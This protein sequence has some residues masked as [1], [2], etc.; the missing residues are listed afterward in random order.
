MVEEWY[1]IFINMEEKIGFKTEML[2]YPATGVHN[3]KISED[4]IERIRK[5]NLVIAMTEYSA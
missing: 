3:T 5:T 4:I 1:K 2:N